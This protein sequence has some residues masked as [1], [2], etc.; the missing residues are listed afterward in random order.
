VGPYPTKTTARPAQSPPGNEAPKRLMSRPWPT[1]VTTQGTQPTHQEMRQKIRVGP[2]GLLGN[3]ACPRAY[4][5]KRVHVR[6]REK[7]EFTH[8]RLLR[9]PCFWVPMNKNCTLWTLRVVRLKAFSLLR[10]YVALDKEI[11]CRHAQ[12][13]TVIMRTS[14]ARRPLRPK[15]QPGNDPDRYRKN[16]ATRNQPRP[17]H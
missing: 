8:P 1:G 6:I 11:T 15:Q 4:G 10:F 14:N 9:A 17:P 3:G 5:A 12:W 2:C 7:E 16:L 13:L